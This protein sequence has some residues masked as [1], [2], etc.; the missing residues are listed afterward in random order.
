MFELV[1][2]NQ[3]G[4]RQELVCSHLLMASSNRVEGGAGRKKNLTAFITDSALELRLNEEFCDGHIDGFFVEGA[5]I[6]P[7]ANEPPRFDMQIA[8][9]I[10]A[11]LSAADGAAW[12]PMLNL[13][14]RGKCMTKG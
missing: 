14:H 4:R 8:A 11:N 5:A 2:Y 12:L 1:R 3:G 6:F 7:T 10:E 9:S 13:I